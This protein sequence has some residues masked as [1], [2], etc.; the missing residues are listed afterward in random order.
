ML[1]FLALL[2]WAPW[3]LD[4]WRFGETLTPAKAAVVSGL[5]TALVAFAAA[6][7]ATAGVVY[8][9]R[10]LAHAREVFMQSQEDS[11]EQAEHARNE[12]RQAEENAAQQAELTR[13]GQINDRYM[14]A[15]ELLARQT[16]SERLGGIYALER[17]MRESEEDHVTV[18]DVLAAFVREHGRPGPTNDES[19]P[20]GQPPR[21]AEDVQ[22]ALTVLGRRPKRTE[23]DVLDLRRTYLCGAD[24]TKANLECA[25]LQ[26][27][28]LGGAILHKTNLK[29]ANLWGT[30]LGGAFL[31]GADL[32][33]TTL[34]DAILRGAQEITV[35]QI[36]AAR[37]TSG[38]TLPAGFADDERVKRRIAEV[39]RDGY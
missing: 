10:N 21:L 35:G 19:L 28:D 15:I 16:F 36:L 31:P 18:V 24:L 39:E 2:I 23:G 7:V 11:R 3:L 1:A 9:H 17:I 22:A 12:L 37:P 29:G 26:G 8:T 13:Q 5:R 4:D 38:T 6:A 30:H 25:I 32:Q 27:A 14:R 33:E 20:P 34:R